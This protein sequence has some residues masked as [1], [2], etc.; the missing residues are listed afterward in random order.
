MCGLDSA[1]GV[2]VCDIWSVY[3]V[4]CACGIFM[5]CV[6]CMYGVCVLFVFCVFVV[7]IICVF[8]IS[9]MTFCV[10]VFYVQYMSVVRVVYICV[11][12]VVCVQCVVYVRSFCGVFV[13][14]L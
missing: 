8:N 9:N 4:W 14:H 13:F 11:V 2:C 5:V 3:N 6:W 10:C 1:C 7:N 12:C